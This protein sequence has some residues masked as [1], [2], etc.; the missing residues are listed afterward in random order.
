MRTYGRCVYSE[1]Y[2]KWGVF[3]LEPHVAIAFKRMFPRVHT[4][5]S[6]IIFS[7]ADDVRADLEWFMLRYPLQIDDD[8]KRVIAEGSERKARRM[9]ERGRILLPTWEPGAFRGFREGRAPYLYQAQGAQIALCNP[10][11]LLGDDVG[12][13]KTVSTL[14]TLTDSSA[15]LPAAAVVQPHLA[16]QWSQAIEEFTTLVPHVIRGTQP[17]SLPKADVYI[18]RYS[19]F[20]GWSDI[21][22]KGVFRSWVFDEIQELR[23]GNKTG[24]GMVA[25]VAV[26]NSDLTLG[27]TATPIYNYGDEIHTVMEYVKPGLLGERYEFMREW[28]GMTKRVADPDALGS[29]LRDTGFFL[30]RTE[31]D[32]IVGLSMPPV[33]VIEWEVGYEQTAVNDEIALTRMLAQRVLAG[34]FVESGKAAREL[35]VKMRLLTGV[36]K[37]RP[38]AAYVK[39]LLEDADRVLLAGWHRDVYEIWAKELE[40]YNP[41]FYTGSESAVRKRQSLHRFTNDTSHDRSRVMFISLRSG[42]GLD[43]LQ[44]HCSDVVFGELDWSP[45]VHYQIIGR[46]R[47]PGQPHQVSGHYLHTDF[48]SDPVLLETLGVKADQSRGLKAPGIAPRPRHSDVSRIQRLARFVLERS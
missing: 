33:N 28:C 5:V 17:Y 42:V 43:G 23:H 2:R 7:D 8:H 15:P 14:A 41:C 29:Y 37:A 22:A 3:D 19:N 25:Q 16:W 13:G 24:K 48:G 34:N 30:R 35:D 21:I 10:N 26:R 47:R 31:D 36:A 4:A 12:L 20:A 38:V 40:R 11:L 27:L 6:P 18:F 32:A 9:E 39:M 44:Q 46:L 45:E 1:K